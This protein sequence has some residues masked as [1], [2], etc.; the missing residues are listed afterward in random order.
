MVGQAAAVRAAH[1]KADTYRMLAELLVTQSRLVEA[2][3][4]LHLLKSEK[5]KETVRGAAADATIKTRTMALSGVQQN[6]ADG[7]FVTGVWQDRKPPPAANKRPLLSTRPT[8]SEQ[9]HLFSNHCA[10]AK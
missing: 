1:S 8:S 6:T 7:F 4:V 10:K 5:L 9:S 3:Q 2:E